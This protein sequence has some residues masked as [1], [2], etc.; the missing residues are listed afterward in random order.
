MVSY[1]AFQLL[2]FAMEK[3]PRKGCK[4]HGFGGCLSDS[5]LR[6]LGMNHSGVLGQVTGIFEAEGLNMS[7]IGEPAYEA[8]SVFVPV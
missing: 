5:V 3:A 7:Q 2:A 8:A 6:P 1:S 4:S